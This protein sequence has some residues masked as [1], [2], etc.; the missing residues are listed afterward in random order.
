M[1]GNTRA[2][3]SF[4]VDDLEAARA[5]YGQTLGLAVSEDAAMG[6]LT[7][8]LAGGHEILVYSKPDHQPASY[9]ALNFT[10]EDIDGAVEQLAGRGVKFQRYEG[11]EQDEKGIARPSAPEQGP[12]IAWFT[13]PAGNILAVLEE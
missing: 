4:S 12:P 6:V 10:V 9:T 3:S 11:F 5:F 7:L 1:F 2:F 13:D 8:R